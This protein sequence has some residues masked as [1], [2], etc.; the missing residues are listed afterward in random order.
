MSRLT[1]QD[2][3][4]SFHLTGSLNHQTQKM[5]IKTE[6]KY[7]DSI[8]ANRIIYTANNITNGFYRLNNFNI[9][10]YQPNQLKKAS[11]IIIP[12]LTVMHQPHFWKNVVNVNQIK[13][14]HSELEQSLVKQVEEE[15]LLL[16][17]TAPKFEDTKLA[18]EQHSEELLTAID[19]IIPGVKEKTNQINIYPTRFGSSMSCDV[20]SGKETEY[21]FE[22]ALREDSFIHEIVEGILTALLYKPTS[23]R[24]NALWQEVELLV[25]WLVDKSRIGEVLNKHYP[26]YTYKPTIDTYKQNRFNLEKDKT[27][28]ILKDLGIKTVSQKFHLQNDQIYFETKRVRYL[29]RS[30]SKLLLHML[31]HPNTVVSYEE[32]NKALGQKEFSL[33][34]ISKAIQRLRDKL[35]RNGIS[36]S[37]IQT[38]RGQGYFFKV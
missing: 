34:A 35:T 30:E 1:F 32:I 19:M 37:F 12:K 6:W 16:N 4:Y 18:W 2:M 31:T 14:T 27:E 11:D 22:I 23:A 25:D 15:I 20:M 3:V 7:S 8:E 36:S 38:V 26:D 13:A 10:L 33:Y 28:V 29:S 5:K 17:L 24:Y 21:N 9:V